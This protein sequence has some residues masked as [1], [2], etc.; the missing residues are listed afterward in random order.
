MNDMG[1]ALDTLAQVLGHSETICIERS[2][3]QYLGLR[4]A[5]Y[6]ASRLI[7]NWSQPVQNGKNLPNRTSQS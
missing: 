6:K 2:L 5:D 4:L 3:S 7:L 1:P